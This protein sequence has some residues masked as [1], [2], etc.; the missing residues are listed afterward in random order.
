[1]AAVPLLLVPIALGLVWSFEPPALREASQGGEPTTVVNGDRVQSTL[2]ENIESRLAESEPEVLVIGNSYALTNVSPEG[3]AKGLGLAESQVMVVA[4]PNTVSSHWYAILKNR[5]Y[6]NGHRPR[7]VIL[8]SDL[9]SALAVSPRSESSLTNLNVHLSDHEPVLE[10]KL[11][12]IDDYTT[13]RLRTNRVKMRDYALKGARNLLVDVLYWREFEQRNRARTNAAMDRVFHAKNTDLRLHTSI[14]PGVAD[15]ELEITAFDP[16]DLPHPR[17]SL[18]PEI[19]Q[20]VDANGGTAVFLRPPM[21][22]LLPDDVGD[23]VPEESE[24]L[25]AKIVDKRAGWYVD[26]RDLDMHAG[27][28]DNV[29]HMNEEGARRFTE[30]TAQLLKQILTVEGKRG[31]PAEYDLFDAV[32]L[33]P[34][35][36]VPT[37]IRARFKAGE[38]PS[39][40]LPDTVGARADVA[41]RPMPDWAHVSD[42]ETRKATPFAA[43]CSPLRV[44]EDGVAL[45][46]PNVPCHEVGEHGLGRACHSDEAVFYTSTDGTQPGDGTHAYTIALDETRSC[47]GGLWLFPDDQARIE[48]PPAALARLDDGA[49]VL[50]LQLYDFGGD[51]DRRAEVRVALRSAKEDFADVVW[52][53]DGAATRLEKAAR[54]EPAVRQGMRDVHLRVENRSDHYLLLTSAVL[55]EKKRKN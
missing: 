17:A 26:L 36:V 25:V 28:F 35:G 23:V 20:L 27:H 6:A 14:G 2:V 21:S 38:L 50:R 18:I 11:Q 33:T 34:R 48:V 32:R 13:R 22:P 42:T 12:Q 53:T 4:V 24:A 39:V 46:L 7:F 3:I 16:A 54:L 5:V 44:L 41:E 49:G 55:A 19:A 52:Q 43:R 15:Y 37:E 30:A 40:E 29:D 1:L 8:L 45:P 47:A 31:R 10:A 9:Q 51:E